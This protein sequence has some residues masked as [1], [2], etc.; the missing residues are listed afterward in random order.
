VSP[1]KA[2]FGYEPTT[3]RDPKEPK[4]ESNKARLDYEQLAGLHEQLSRDIDFYTTRM[5]YY[6]NKKHSKTPEYEIGSK[7]YLLRRN[8]STKRPS[9]KLDFVKLGPFRIKGKPTK[10]NVTLELPKG[11]RIHPTFH[12]SLIEPAPDS[13]PV[14]TKAE[15]R[16]E[17]EK[18]YEVEKILAVRITGNRPY[19]LIKWK[20]YDTSENTWEPINNLNHCENLRIEFHRENPGQPTETVTPRKFEERVGRN[21]RAGPELGPLH[22][23]RKN[24]EPRQTLQ[25]DPSQSRTQG[26]SVAFGGAPRGQRPRQR[27]LEP[28]KPEH[29][30]RRALRRSDR[31]SQPTRRANNS[32]YA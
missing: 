2:N 28:P 18:H 6:Y 9:K 12:V 19:Y 26:G 8:I 22:R 10:V 32:S 3:R 15:G 21:R 31:V 20:G 17:D 4:T 24:G 16:N 25:Q 7:V 29:E 27:P 11:M 14:Q 30:G 5:A 1:Y 13:V 23:F